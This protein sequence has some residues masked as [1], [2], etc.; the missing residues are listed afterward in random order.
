GSAVNGRV[1][2]GAAG[3]SQAPNPSGSGGKVGRGR[4]GSSARDAKKTHLSARP[5]AVAEEAVI[6][7]AEARSETHRPPDVLGATTSKAVAV[8]STEGVNGKLRGEKKVVNISGTP[9]NSPDQPRSLGRDSGRRRRR[10]RRRRPEEEIEEELRW[11]DINVAESNDHDDS[12]VVDGIRARW[13]KLVGRGPPRADRSDD[14]NAVNAGDDTVKNDDGDASSV[15]AAAAPPPRG[16]FQERFQG[17]FRKRRGGERETG[18]EDV[19]DDVLDM[20]GLG[21]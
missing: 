20:V 9:P 8:G 3:V 16:S 14:K 19:D 21:A 18:K 1:S 7:V 2:S 17:W 6:P 5:G 12:T 13:A 11:P 15:T 10:H 4:K